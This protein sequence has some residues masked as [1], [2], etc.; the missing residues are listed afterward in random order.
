MKGGAVHVVMADPDG[1]E[2]CVCPSTY[3]QDS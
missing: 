2:F 3:T 1:N